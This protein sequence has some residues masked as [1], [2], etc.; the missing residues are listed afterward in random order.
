MLNLKAFGVIWKAVKV[1]EDS[2]SKGGKFVYLF[3]CQSYVNKVILKSVNIYLYYKNNDRFFGESE[4]AYVD[5]GR[6]CTGME[7][8][9]EKGRR[10]REVGSPT[11]FPFPVMACGMQ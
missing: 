11:E 9:S 4:G 8:K 5:I 6:R 7:R 2:F 1:H 10:G 3:V